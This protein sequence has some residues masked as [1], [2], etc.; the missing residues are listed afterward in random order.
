MSVTT[1]GLTKHMTPTHFD[2]GSVNTVQNDQSKQFYAIISADCV[3]HEPEITYIKQRP[4]KLELDE[5][6]IG[7]KMLKVKT[8]QC[9]S[10]LQFL[11]TWKHSH[12]LH[13]KTILHQV[14]RSGQSA[15]ELTRKKKECVV[16]LSVINSLSTAG[17]ILN[18]NY[19]LNWIIQRIYSVLKQTKLQIF[20]FPQVEFKRIAINKIKF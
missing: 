1:R 4:I 7:F 9:F 12:V 19:Q 13:Q 14:F 15:P 3:T 18:I 16:K 8:V 2:E 17:K 10:F 20:S 5:I 6:S 11:D